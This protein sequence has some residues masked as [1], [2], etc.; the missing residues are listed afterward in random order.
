MYIISYLDALHPEIL[1]KECEQAGIA[2]KL[3][4]PISQVVNV[5]AVSRHCDRNTYIGLLWEFQNRNL[6]P[7][8]MVKLNH[9]LM[10]QLSLAMC[11]LDRPLKATENLLHNSCRHGF[12][13]Y[14]DLTHLGNLVLQLYP[15]R[16]F[17]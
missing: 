12:H 9:D 8:F 13:L 15:L 6:F 10:P 7:P 11:S 1:Q 17:K 14:V 2:V 3:Q 4:P 16:T 5:V